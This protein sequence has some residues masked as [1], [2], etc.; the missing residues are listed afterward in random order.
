MVADEEFPA[1]PKQAVLEAAKVGG[2][3]QIFLSIGAGG[4]A[5]FEPHQRLLRRTA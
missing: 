3:G 4:R 2:G 5:R 1:P